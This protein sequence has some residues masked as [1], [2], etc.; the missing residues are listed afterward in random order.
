MRL[1]KKPFL[2]IGVMLFVLAMSMNAFAAPAS[3]LSLSAPGPFN[4]NDTFDLKINITGTGNFTG[5][6][7]TITF[8]VAN[9]QVT[10]VTI[11]PTVTSGA[12]TY[13]NGV[14]APNTTNANN[15][16]HADAGKLKFTGSTSDSAGLAPISPLVTV[17]FK[18]TTAGTNLQIGGT[19]SVTDTSFGTFSS[20]AYSVPAMNLFRLS[21]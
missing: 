8:P 11:N 15:P 14:V 17:T 7:E 6:D 18:C 3:S 12:I 1:K 16:A 20:P 10:A 19:Y 21:R 5:L 9:L 13:S 2:I 4:V